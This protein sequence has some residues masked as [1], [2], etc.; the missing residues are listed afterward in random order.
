MMEKEI[1]LYYNIFTR[2]VLT[3]NVDELRNGGI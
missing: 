3:E 2:F 1:C